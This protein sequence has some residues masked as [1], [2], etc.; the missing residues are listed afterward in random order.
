MRI[1]NDV[2]VELLDSM[3]NDAAIV[4]AAR[5]SFGKEIEVVGV[6]DERLIAYLA[7]HKHTSPFNHA[8][9]KFRVEAPIFV[10]RQLVKH[11]YLVWNEISRRYVTED[12]EFYLPRV[13]R[14]SA[15][16]VKQGSSD[17][18]VDVDHKALEHYIL[19]QGQL[20][21]DLINEGKICPEQARMLLPQNLMT[22]WIW[23]G[24]LGAFGKMLR[25]RQDAHTQ[26][27]SRDVANLIAPHVLNL[28]PVAGKAV[29]EMQ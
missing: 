3:G 28:F 11:E 9:L 8:F 1:T 7:K 16:N 17:E 25:L 23:S 4:N 5:V 29:L 26:K 20:Y 12:L 19:N 24:S 14:K 18:E 13:W 22:K 21:E 6:A 27:E 15:E 10:A 2:K